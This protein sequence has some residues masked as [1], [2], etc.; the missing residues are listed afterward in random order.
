MSKKNK[1]ESNKNRNKQVDNFFYKHFN[2]NVEDE[3]FINTI[4]DNVYNEV[5]SQMI[6]FAT[7]GNIDYNRFTFMLSKK[8]N[9]NNIKKDEKN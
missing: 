2:D 4:I 5:N 6:D 9:K 3:N 7:I 8:I 1:E